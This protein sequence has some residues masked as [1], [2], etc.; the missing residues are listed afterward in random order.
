M[1]HGDIVRSSVYWSL[2]GMLDWVW[3]ALKRVLGMIALT[4]LF[5]RVWY[6]E[7]VFFLG[8][9]WADLVGCMVRSPGLSFPGFVSLT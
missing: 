4:L 6:I 2:L 9:F 7:P 3:S 8:A 1:R 5:R